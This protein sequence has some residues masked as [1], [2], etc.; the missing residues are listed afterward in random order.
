[1]L[2]DAIV[3]CVLLAL[4]RTRSVV[5]LQAMV[6]FAFAY[7]CVAALSLWPTGLRW[8]C[9]GIAFVLGGAIQL[10][11]NPPAALGLLAVLY[12]FTY[13]SLR[14]SLEGFPWQL[15]DW[16]P[17]FAVKPNATRDDRGPARKSLGWPFDFLQPIAPNIG[18]RLSDGTATCG[19][20]GWWAYSVI[21]NIPADEQM[22]VVFIVTWVIGA[23]AAVRLA[24]YCGNYWWPISLRGRLSTGRFI[25][26]RFDRVFVAP[27]LALAVQ[28][29]GL[30]VTVK[31]QYG[32]PLW[33]AAWSSFAAWILVNAGPSLAEWQLTGGHRISPG[34][35]DRQRF[36]QL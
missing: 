33:F 19:L 7:Q 10:F 27:L 14:R 12:P 30:Y 32:D 18:I 23:A 21:R 13:L 1:V 11:P 8:R 25:I 26:P 20:A 17:R 2:Q 4:M 35:R 3:L 24:I 9:Y 28:I 31:L 36:I 29:A 15:P 34:I 5:L 16:W 22:K 6:G